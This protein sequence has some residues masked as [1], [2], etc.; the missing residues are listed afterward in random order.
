MTEPGTTR[1]SPE[2]ERSIREEG[3]PPKRTRDGEQD[4]PAG[5]APDTPTFGDAPEPVSPADE[6][7]VQG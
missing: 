6:A 3:L 5:Q 1:P 7:T 4:V 2:A